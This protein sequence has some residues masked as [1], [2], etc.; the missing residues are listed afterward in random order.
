MK[1]NYHIH[2]SYSGDI[3]QANRLSETPEKYILAAL[4]RGFDE[5]C[6]TEHLVA[7]YPTT[8]HIYSHGIDAGKLPGYVREIRFLAKKY[9]QLKIRL[10][11]EVDWF[12]EKIGEIKKTL[13]Q[14]PFDCVLGSV[15]IL[16][17]ARIEYETEGG[18]EAF[19]GRLSREEVYERHAAY[20]RAVQEMAK[21]KICDI[22]SHID[23]VKRDARI[24]EKSTQPLILETVDI[25]AENNLCVEVNTA[26]IRKQINEMHP[27][28]EILRLC[29]KKGI[30]V[31]IGTDAHKVEEFD[32]HL[33]DGMKMIKEAGY[34]EIAVFE[35][36][37]RKIVKI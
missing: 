17:G 32:F 31:T 9:P 12:P 21:S 35:H 20:Y 11:I 14:Y 13:R 1:I 8:A 22:I 29:R 5:I 27:T 25:I 28:L 7:G 24:P 4:G 6:F 10:G 34:N 36:R 3:V 16:D 26:G 19:W 2:T 30:P 33:D 23:L 37:K 15:H 18:R